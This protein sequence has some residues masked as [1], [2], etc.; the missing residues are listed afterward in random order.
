LDDTLGERV[1]IDLDSDGES[2]SLA[3]IPLA[4]TCGTVRS[5]TRDVCSLSGY[6]GST[7]AQKKT[8]RRVKDAKNVIV[9][10]DNELFDSQGDMP[11]PFDD[12]GGSELKSLTSFAHHNSLSSA[13]CESITDTADSRSD[14]RDFNPEMTGDRKQFEPAALACEM[15]GWHARTM[16]QLESHLVALHGVIESQRLGRR[17]AHF[18]CPLC[19]KRYRFRAQLDK[20]RLQ[21]GSGVGDRPHRC[22]QCRNAYRHAQSL[23][24]HNCVHN[25]I[26]T[27]CGVR[28]HCPACNKTYPNKVLFQK[29]IVYMHERMS[30]PG[31]VLPQDGI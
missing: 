6:L 3:D 8:F 11:E 13:D 12:F 7:D 17:I 21:H 26:A 10:E 16:S 30:G 20:H 19:G 22:Q 29:H 23:A 9:I 14:F 27:Q 24:L 15:C 4:D 5:T 1:D 31:D 28:L 18:A 2:P 25:S